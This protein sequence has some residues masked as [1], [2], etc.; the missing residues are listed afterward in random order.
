MTEGKGNNNSENMYCHK[1]LGKVEV[2]K[3]GEVEVG[4]V[5]V[6]TVGEGEVSKVGKVEVGKVEVGKIGKV[7][8]GELGTAQLGYLDKPTSFNELE[9]HVGTSE[10][11]LIN[12]T[13]RKIKLLP[14]RERLQTFSLLRPR[15]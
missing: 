13:K 3:V 15:Q 7:Q 4:K 14:K 6:G 2:G 9:Q 12:S 10:E 5:E 8:V 11:E 1:R